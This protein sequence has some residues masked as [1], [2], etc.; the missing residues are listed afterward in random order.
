MASRVLVPMSQAPLGQSFL[1][2]N[3]QDLLTLLAALKVEVP[4]GSTKALL[5]ALPLLL[6]LLLLR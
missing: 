5:T 1:K 3:R 4:P 6:L 2:A